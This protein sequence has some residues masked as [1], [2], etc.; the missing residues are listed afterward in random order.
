MINLIKTNNV[1]DYAYEIIDDEIIQTYFI[2]KDNDIIKAKKKHVFYISMYGL[3]FIQ[4]LE[5]KGYKEINVIKQ[6]YNLDDIPVIEKAKM[7]IKR[8]LH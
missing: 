6:K 8:K 7:K 5:G 3:I 2:V 4:K 1:I